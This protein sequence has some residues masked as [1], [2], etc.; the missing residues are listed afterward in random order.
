MSDKIKTKK[1]SKCEQ[2]KDHSQYYIRPN[3][4]LYSQ[5]NPCKKI[6]SKKWYE[7]N[8]ENGEKYE[9]NGK[10]CPK[11]DEYKLKNEYYI[12]KKNGQMSTY[13]ADCEA[14]NNSTNNINRK[15]T[16]QKW[17]MN[18]K[19]HVKMKQ[20]EY[21]HNTRQLNIQYRLTQSLRAEMH[22]VLN[23][24]NSSEELLGCNVEFFMK[25]LEFQFNNNMNWDNYGKYWEIDH[26][27]PCASYKLE[28]LE[29][30]KICFNWTNLRPLEV[31]KNRSKKDKIIKNDI[32][33]QNLNIMLF[34]RQH[35]QI[36]GTS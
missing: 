30:Q 7:Q 6:S 12:L 25:W 35:V 22:R 19:D 20:L 34:K 18:N 16:K 23:K 11:C 5:C 8:M 29:E 10:I 28:E 4:N 26:T 13:C 2:V 17:I 27:T 32:I 14:S 15:T 36:A 33:K 9:V 21:H 1:C 3:G 24:K 31:A